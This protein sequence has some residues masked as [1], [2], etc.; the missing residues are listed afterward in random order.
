MCVRVSL[1]ARSLQI[2]E[3]IIDSEA[4]TRASLSSHPHHPTICGLGY[5]IS[6]RSILACYPFCCCNP[7]CSDDT[8]RACSHHASHTLS[9]KLKPHPSAYDLALLHTYSAA[10]P[11]PFVF[12]PSR[13]RRITHSRCLAPS[14]F[15][16]VS[17]LPLLF[18]YY[19]NSLGQNLKKI[20]SPND[21]PRVLS[22]T[23][24][25]LVTP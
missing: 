12:S 7:S 9:A 21:F 25:R 17:Y 14:R 18:L 20:V 4:N 13:E 3:L 22:S 15:S 1:L 5:S 8:P 10:L 11:L 19:I 16:V 24:A 6:Q 23:I 2:T